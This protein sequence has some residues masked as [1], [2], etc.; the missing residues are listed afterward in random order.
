MD[1]ATWMKAHRLQLN[2]SKTQ[3]LVLKPR[4]PHVLSQHQNWLPVPC[5]VRYLAGMVDDQLTFSNHA[6]YFARSCRLALH[7]NQRNQTFCNSTCYSSPDTSCCHLQTWFLQC[8]PYGLTKQAQ[9]HPFRRSRT[10]RPAWST[11]ALKGHPAAHRS[12]LASCCSITFKSLKLSHKVVSSPAR[13]P[14]CT[15][16]GIC[17]LL[18]WAT[19]G[20]ATRPLKAI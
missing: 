10:Q 13:L 16:T 20:S 15:Y 5:L 6:A 19:P 12:P 4:I 11:T 2:L 1:V 8:P 18:H 14:E 7:K 17:Y 9:W 3:L